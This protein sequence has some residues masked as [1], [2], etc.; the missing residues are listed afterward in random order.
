MDP[1][2]I[3]VGISG[4]LSTAQWVIEALK[5]S[6]TDYIAEFNIYTRILTNVSKDFNLG[7]PYP[8]LAGECLSLCNTRLNIVVREIEAR[9]G[10]KKHL[11][12]S[13]KAL[14]D[15]LKGFMDAVRIFRDV[16]MEYVAMCTVTGASGC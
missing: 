8:D 15:A 12:P 11:K 1:L 13:E 7:G 2:S 16:V 3:V 14:K 4:L 6:S 9:S 10:A 5:K